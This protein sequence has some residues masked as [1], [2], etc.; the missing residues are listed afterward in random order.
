M[1]TLPNSDKGTVTVLD[2][3]DCDCPACQASLCIEELTKVSAE[4][5]EEIGQLK[6]AC[7]MFR[8]ANERLQKDV[9]ICRRQ[10]Q[11]ECERSCRLRDQRDEATERILNLENTKGENL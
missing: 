5:R 1:R 10:L 6:A 8:A 2:H 4:Q 7:G 3:E 11:R 9:E